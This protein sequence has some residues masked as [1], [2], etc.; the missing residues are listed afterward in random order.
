MSQLPRLLSILTMLRSK[1]LVTGVT[2]A[3][4]FGVSLRTVYRDIRKLEEAGVPVVTIEGKGY[5]I[6]DGYSLPPVHFD[7]AE[8]N[9][10]I[11]AE[12]LIAKTKNQ[13]L[14]SDF[15]TAITKIKSTF[16]SQMQNKTEL[17]DERMYVFASS[18]TQMD[19]QSLSALQLAMTNQQ[20]VHISYKKL[21]TDEVSER[22]IEPTAM[23]SYDNKWI[24]IAWCHLRDEYRT[25]RLDCIV[26]YRVLSQTFADRQFEF[27]KYFTPQEKHKHP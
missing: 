13:S 17:L 19:S 9:A 8:V 27:G 7:Q 18:S 23:Y 22:D 25:F 21:H 12:K 10:L 5:S 4:K 2:I 16:Q 20:V 15:N 24:V 11:T 26:K 1:R 14:I 6:M 3:E